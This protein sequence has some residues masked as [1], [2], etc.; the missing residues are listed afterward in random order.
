MWAHRFTIRKGIRHKGDI[1]PHFE[2][3]GIQNLKIGGLEHNLEWVK[4]DRLEGYFWNRNIRGRILQRKILKLKQAGYGLD[5][6]NM[7]IGI[8]R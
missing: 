1:V 5:K 4:R 2:R 7:G 6:G 3:H 8:I